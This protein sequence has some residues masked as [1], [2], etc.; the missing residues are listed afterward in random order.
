MVL[1]KTRIVIC[2]IVMEYI[3]SSAGH[4]QSIFWIVS[5]ISDIDFVAL[6]AWFSSFIAEMEEIP[7]LL[8]IN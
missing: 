2:C 6:K 4:G 8:I 7:Q 5:A 3:L 1:S